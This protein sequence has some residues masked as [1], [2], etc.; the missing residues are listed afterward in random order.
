[1][2]TCNDI[3]SIDIA[4]HIVDES[5]IA[6]FLLTRT[7]FNFNFHFQFHVSFHATLVTINNDVT[8]TVFVFQHYGRGRG[9][10]TGRG[11]HASAGV[12]PWDWPWTNFSD[13]HQPYQ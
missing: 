10:R 11:R 3:C 9:R 5:D 7:L 2:T 6:N 1:M 12:W 13:G 4:S 8:Q